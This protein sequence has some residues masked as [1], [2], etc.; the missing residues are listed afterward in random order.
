MSDALSA[1]AGETSPGGTDHGGILRPILALLLFASG[2]PSRLTAALRAVI[3]PC[4]DF[5]V[6]LVVVWPG[7]V[8]NVHSLPE[9]GELEVVS[10][11]PE[12]DLME[13]R[14]I[15][16]AQVNADL[17]MFVEERDVEHQAWSD[18]LA[19]RVGFLRGTKPD[20]PGVDWRAALADLGVKPDADNS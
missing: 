1:P 20:E 7:P 16:A 15:A 10:V 4:S 2:Q 9:A 14:R 11:P 12:S 13:R 18:V 19:S 3:R 8:A 6:R 17:M 5:G